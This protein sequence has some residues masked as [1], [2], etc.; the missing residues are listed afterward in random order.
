MN[1]RC[2]ACNY[3]LG[4]RYLGAVQARCTNCGVRLRAN[5][6]PIHAGFGLSEFPFL[7]AA[8]VPIAAYELFG[9]SGT[10]LGLV[11]LVS[12]LAC[13]SYYVLRIDRVPSDWPR[14]VVN[15]RDRVDTTAGGKSEAGSSSSKNAP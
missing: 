6:H 15:Y 12:L 4:G 8:L 5:V 3:D 2:P 10:A 14:Y 13:V 9:V 7:L 1:S 11:A